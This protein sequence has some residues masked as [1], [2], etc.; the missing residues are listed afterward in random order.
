[1]K[2]RKIPCFLFL[3]PLIVIVLMW[4]NLTQ[5]VLQ[6]FEARSIIDTTPAA[7]VE[8]DFRQSQ[9]PWNHHVTYFDHNYF[10]NER[11]L[12]PESP[13]MTHSTT[14][15]AP[16]TDSEHFTDGNT[17]F[18]IAD[19]FAFPHP[20][21]ALKDRTQLLDSGWVNK[22]KWILLRWKPSSRKIIM[23]S[24]NYQYIAVLLNWLISTVVVARLNLDNILVVSLDKNTHSLLQARGICSL[25]VIPSSLFEKHVTPSLWMTRLIIIRLLNHWGYDV[26]HFD[27]DALIV[28]NPEPLFDQFNESAIIG[29]QGSFPSTLSHK[30]GATIC[31]GVMVIRSCKETGIYVYI[32]M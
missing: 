14:W 18:S 4:K 21:G 8:M 22:L 10:E 12:L 5:E 23:V 32:H 7:N 28:Q 30:W 26:A 24:S 13:S 15:K 17:R 6:T 29:S 31:A 3:I 1:M 27:A 25:L 9:T 16:T 11:I 2:N 20:G 19:Y